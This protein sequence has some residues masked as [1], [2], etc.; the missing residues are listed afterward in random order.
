MVMMRLNG[1]IVMGPKTLF[2]D[3]GRGEEEARGRGGLD[4]ADDV[5]GGAHAIT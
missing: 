4:I 3:D 2:I 1:G 5:I